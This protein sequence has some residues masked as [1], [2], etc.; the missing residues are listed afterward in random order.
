MVPCPFV[1]NE[2]VEWVIDEIKVSLGYYST[3][4]RRKHNRSYDIL[5]FSLPAVH[6]SKFSD[7]SKLYWKEILRNPTSRIYLIQFEICLQIILLDNKYC[8]LKMLFL[9][10]DVFVKKSLK[11]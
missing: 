3:F 6:V 7:L 9:Q 11:I 5:S 8:S 4:I 2:R 1:K 10:H